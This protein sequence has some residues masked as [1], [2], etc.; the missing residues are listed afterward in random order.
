MPPES[1]VYTLR[2][3]GGAFRRVYALK[4]TDNYDITNN[5]QYEAFYPSAGELLV[6]SIDKVRTYG[7][8]FQLTVIPIHDLSV[9][10]GL[11]L[12][13]SK[14]EAFA[15]DPTAVGN[16][17]P[18]TPDYNFAFTVD[19]SFR[20]TDNISGFTRFDDTVRG[21]QY[22]E[23]DDIPGTRT[24]VVNLANIRA[25]LKGKY[26][27]VTAYAKNLG[28]NRYFASNVVLG[29]GLVA[30]YLAPPR[31]YGLEVTVGF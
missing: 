13:D 31:I 4:K 2:Q 24:N 21:T 12:I 26:W 28:D 10:F 27:S 9:T 11:G 25:G 14:I 7:A 18:D 29:S 6:D 20:V 19:K 23:P 8:E 16:R 30:T 22:W 5:Q 15:A 3:T 17:P 1:S